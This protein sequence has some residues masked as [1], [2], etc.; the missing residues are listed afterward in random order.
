MWELSSLSIFIHHINF[1][2]LHPCYNFH[3]HWF[4]FIHIM[5][6]ITSIKLIFILCSICVFNFVYMVKSFHVMNPM[7]MEGFDMRCLESFIQFVIF[8][9]FMEFIQIFDG[10][11]AQFHPSA[12]TFIHMVQ[13]CSIIVINFRFG[14]MDQFPFIHV[15][16]FGKK[17]NYYLVEL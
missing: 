10:E 6:L 15:N 12:P 3:L 14:H 5:N 17:T 11:M 13:I 4:N 8:I 9:F 16:H 7:D 1:I 2:K